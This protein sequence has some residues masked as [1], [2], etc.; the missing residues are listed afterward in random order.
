MYH[1]V[2][3]MKMKKYEY[4]KKKLE[5]LEGLFTRKLKPIM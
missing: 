2:N 5:M 3:Y 1:C 4:E